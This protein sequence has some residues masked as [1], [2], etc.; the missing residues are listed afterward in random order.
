M[1]KQKQR[2]KPRDLLVMRRRCQLSG[3]PNRLLREIDVAAVSLVEDQ[4]QHFQH[5]AQISRLIE[6]HVA[7]GAFRPA[8]PLRHGRF[9]HE[10]RLRNLARGEPAHGAQRQRDGRRG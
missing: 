2:K 4:I 10:I 8:D 6:S 7:H 5:R 1:V 3:Q 9:R